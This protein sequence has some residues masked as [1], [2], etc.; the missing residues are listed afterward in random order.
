[1]VE[2]NTHILVTINV[3]ICAVN[4]CKRISRKMLLIVENG[5]NTTVLK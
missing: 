3:N 1:M 4:V 5:K 2:E